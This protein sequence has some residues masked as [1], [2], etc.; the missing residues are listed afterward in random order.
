MMNTKTLVW[1][2]LFIGSTI[3][4]MIPSIWGAGIFSISSILLSALGGLVGIFLGFKLGSE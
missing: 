3:G 2:G 4:S 1:I